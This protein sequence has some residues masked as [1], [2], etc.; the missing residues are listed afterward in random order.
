MNDNIRAWVQALRSGE[1]KQGTGTLRNANSEY[2]CLGVACELAMRDGVG[3]RAEIVGYRVN[4]ETPVHHGAMPNVVA[5]WLGVEHDT[6]YES[7]DMKLEIGGDRVK[8]LAEM[9]DEMR[10]T[11]KQIADVIEN[12]LQNGE[13]Q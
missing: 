11:F 12:N 4:G 6:R 13:D 7:G 3:I 9:N 2:C 5:A 1:F 8:F 10:M